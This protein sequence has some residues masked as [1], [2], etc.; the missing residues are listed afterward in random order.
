MERVL[1]VPDTHI[2]Y[3]DKRAWQLLLKAGKAF[4][5]DTIVICGD[6][7]DFYAVSDHNKDPRRERFLEDEVSSVIT[8]L[9]EL[10]YLNAR[11]KIYVA[12][13]HEDRLARYLMTRAPELFRTVNIPDVLQ[14]PHQGWIYVPYKAHYKVGK[15]YITHDC[16]KA[17]K[18]AHY[19]ALNDFQ[20]NVVIGH[21]HRIGYTVVG[22]AKGKPH[23]GAMFG[24]LGDVRQ[25]DYMHSIKANRDWALG[26]GI[27]YME[28]NGTIHLQPVPIVDY[29]V[30]VEGKLIT[31]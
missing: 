20:D 17:G 14:L 18:T 24:W 10:S 12:G 5:P 28:P 6:F 25:V 16:G 3:H 13:N 30:V 15:L 22:N 19:D 11:K 21:T 1:F 29:K 31:L 8:A 9:H 27:G 7:A 4:K 23:V 2:P 26:F